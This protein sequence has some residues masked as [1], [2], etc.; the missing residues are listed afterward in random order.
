MASDLQRSPRGPSDPPRIREPF[1][2]TV[3][4]H[5]TLPTPRT[6]AQCESILPRE[7]SELPGFTR[8]DC[9]QLALKLPPCTEM[10]AKVRHRLTC[11]GKDAAQHTCGFHTWLR[12]GRL[13]ATFPSRP[14][15]PYDSNIWRWWTDSRA[16]RHPPAEPPLPPPSWMDQ[17][18]FPTFV[19]CTPL[20]L[21]ANTRHHVILRTVKEM[22]E[23][24]RLKLRGEVR[25]PL[26]DANGTA[27]SLP[28][29]GANATHPCP[30]EPSLFPT[31]LSD[32]LPSLLWSPENSTLSKR[33]WGDRL[34]ARE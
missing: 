8:Q 3:H 33:S 24:R 22:R 30:G 32:V 20:F 11:P 26:L 5:E 4:A 25:A 15:R 7:S 13:P 27:G 14:D 31:P 17:N 9:H 19:S 2:K 12:V 29:Q 18:S 10:K 23:A 21:D 6:W 34:E 16:H 28:P 1:L